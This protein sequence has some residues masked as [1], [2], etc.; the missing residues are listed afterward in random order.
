MTDKAKRKG[1]SNA[2]SGRMRVTCPPH[3][4]GPIG[5]EHDPERGTGVAVGECWQ[6][7]L[8]CRQWGTHLPHVAGIAGQANA[9]AQSVVLSGAGRLSCALISRVQMRVHAHSARTARAGGYEDD[10]DEGEWFLY[11]GSGGRDLS[12][13]KRTS[14]VQTS[15][16]VFE[17]SNKALRTSCERGLPVRVVRSHKEARSAYAPTD[18]EHGVRYDGVYKIVA[19]WRL[20][21]Q[22]GPLVCRYLFRRCDNEPAPWCSASDTGDGPWAAEALPD[23]ATAELARATEAVTHP[24]AAPAWDYDAAT[25]RWGWATAPPVPPPAPGRA[26]PDT[27]VQAALKHVRTVR[28]RPHKRTARESPTR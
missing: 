11:T 8:H 10:R 27:P 12:G 7:R 26:A 22:Q 20:P 19:C 21:G 14:K 3:H 4:F 17:S 24:A 18:A 2:A 6:S 23:E 9:G 16:Q 25:A 13:N 28:R 5:P 1:L 15:D